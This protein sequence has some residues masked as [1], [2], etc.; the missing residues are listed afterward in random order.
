M[1]EPTN[2]QWAAIREE[3][4]AGRMIGAIKLYREATGAGLK[5]AKDAVDLKAA[6]PVAQLSERSTPVVRVQAEAPNQI[7]LRK[8][9]AEGVGEMVSFLAAL[10]A[11]YDENNPHKAPSRAGAN[12]P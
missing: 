8:T 7:E 3:V 1:T 6:D 9:S 10:H 4:A 5:E 2:E 12:R 11:L